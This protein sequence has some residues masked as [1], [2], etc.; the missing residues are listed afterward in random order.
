[1][2]NELTVAVDLDDVV[3]DFFGGVVIRG[4]NKDFAARLDVRDVTDWDHN[5]VKHFDWSYYGY[6]SWWEWLQE[7]AKLW[8]T[9]PAI[10]GAIGGIRALRAAGHRPQC[11]TAKP[12]WAEPQV[13]RWL[14][15]WQPAFESV[16]FVPVDE[17]KSVATDADVLIDDR[18]SNCAEW[19]NSDS[20]RF[21]VL[22]DQP[23]NDAVR[24]CGPRT[25]WAA[26]W[27]AVLDIVADL[28]AS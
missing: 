28:E 7:R 9:A 18:A 21:A 11:V 4:M 15:R 1:M 17:P 2:A 25:F 27:P 6:S 16:H 20:T 5:L 19:V 13:W 3:L 12:T 8:A 26:D 10:D 23:W 24:D 22:F 14:G